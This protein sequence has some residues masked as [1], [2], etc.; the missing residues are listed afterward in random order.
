[1]VIYFFF[2][3]EG[4]M[5][6]VDGFV[7]LQNPDCSFLFFLLMIVLMMRDEVLVTVSRYIVR[8]P[9]SFVAISFTAYLEFIISLHRIE[10]SVCCHDFCCCSWWVVLMPRTFD[11]FLST[12]LSSSSPPHRVVSIGVVAVLL[13]PELGIPIHQ[14]LDVQDGLFDVVG[15]S[16]AND[17]FGHAPTLGRRHVDVDLVVSANVLDLGTPGP[18][19]AVKEFLRHVD[20][21]VDASRVGD[22]V[23][24]VG[25]NVLDDLLGLL[26][27]CRAVAGDPDADRG[28]DVSNLCV[29]YSVWCYV[30]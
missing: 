12:Y 8:K 17:V 19:N 5:G 24:V 18:D 4:A 25:A 2:S 27:V 15:L 14:Q 29:V 13:F 7:C 10:V 28:D 23:V 1:M 30:T 16:D 3:K 11:S 21:L 26:D 22:R 9:L 20:L 6:S